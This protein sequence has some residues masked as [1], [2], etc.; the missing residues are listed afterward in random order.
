MPPLCPMARQLGKPVASGQAAVNCP[1]KSAV[2]GI[3]KNADEEPERV[4]VRADELHTSQVSMKYHPSE[5]ARL[6]L[7]PH[8]EHRPALADRFLLWRSASGA[9]RTRTPLAHRAFPFLFSPPSLRLW[10]PLRQGSQ[11]AGWASTATTNRLPPRLSRR[12]PPAST[13]SSFASSSSITYFALLTGA[14]AQKL[15]LP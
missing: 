6:V 11:P 10:P 3:L 7:T 12:S 8:T 4:P 5:P 9:G 1:L 13:G 2:V 14:S 15:R